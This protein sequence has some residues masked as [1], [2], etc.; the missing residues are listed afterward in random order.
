VSE[1]TVRRIKKLQGS[2]T[3]PGD[4]SISHRAAMLSLLC[5]K[6]LN[7]SHYADGVDCRKSLEAIQLCGA[8]VEEHDNVLTITPPEKV[9]APL[10]PIDC[11]NS[12][13]TMRLMAGL[14]AGAGIEAYLTGD[15]SLSQRPMKRIIEPLKKMN[16]TI[17]GSEEGTAPLTVSPGSLIPVDYILPVASAQVKSSLLLAALASGSG[18]TI[19]EKAITRDH[20]ER[21]IDYLG[22]DITIEDIVAE[23]IPDPVDPRKKK[24]VLPTEDYCR[25]IL[26]KPRVVLTGGDISIPGDVSTAAYFIAAAL[27]IPGSH[28]IIKEV[29]V[30]PTRIGFITLLKQ[31]GAEIT[32]SNKRDV[33]GETVADIEAV[34]SA[35]KPRKISGAAIPNL[36][37]ELP[38]IAVIASQLKGTTII[39][40]A[41]EL[42]HKECDR[43][44]AVVINL[45]A[46]GV[47]VG[48]FP[49]GMAIEG[50]S[51]LHGTRLDSFGD[52]RIAMAFTI[53][54]AVAYGDSVITE[55]ESVDISC[56]SF[57]TMLEGLRS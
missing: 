24:R 55:S 47:K 32:I 3:L 4:K 46:M 43:I 57:F 33:C 12:G 53:A 30:N 11:G 5:A 51:D 48:E 52:H 34:Y 19:R 35:L 27:L 40:D 39:R 36:I 41:E 15:E 6:P 28:V 7:I 45:Q 10:G 16:A 22:G 37:D 1:T 42:R 50:P 14:T 8:R 31:M 26:L 13:T 23:V 2:I 17:D 9:Q 29:G 20:T 38:V 21:M 54:A 44:H 25:S 18:V 49:D 56:P